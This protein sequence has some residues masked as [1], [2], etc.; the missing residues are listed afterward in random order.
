[1]FT[2]LDHEE[3]FQ[4]RLTELAESHCR[5]GVKSTEYA[6]FGEVIFWTLKTCLG[7]LCFPII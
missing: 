6:I 1:M 2:I 4:T 7:E 3:Q 5:R